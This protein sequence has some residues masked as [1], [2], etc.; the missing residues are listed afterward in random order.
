MRMQHSLPA[1]AAILALG[2]TQGAAAQSVFN[3]GPPAAPVPFNSTRVLSPWA[4]LTR[5]GSPAANYYQGVLPEYQR[6][7]EMNMPRLTLELP[8]YDP[9]VDDRINLDVLEKQLP[10]TG[11]PTGFLIYNSYFNNLPNQRSFM[12][13][14]PATGKQIR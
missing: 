3:P 12:P 13:Y 11:H 8:R 5:G 9:T 7:N 6:R 4:E 10:P 14:N 1:L 2:W